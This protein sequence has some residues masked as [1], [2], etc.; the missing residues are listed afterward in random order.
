[1]RDAI[2]KAIQRTKR[3][4]GLD[5]VTAE[6]IIE[7]GYLTNL[8]GFANYGTIITEKFTLN[9]VQD[10]FNP[11]VENYFKF[12]K[13]K[14]ANVYNPN[15]SLVSERGINNVCFST[16]HQAKGLE[17]SHVFIGNDIYYMPED[18]EYDVE[19]E[20]AEFNLAYVCMTRAKES[21]SLESGSSLH[22]Q[23]QEAI[24]SGF[25]RKY[26]SKNVIVEEKLSDTPQFIAK[27]Q[28]N[29]TKEIV[30]KNVMFLDNASYPNYK[31]ISVVSNEVGDVQDLA[32]FNDYDF[33]QD[34][35]MRTYLKP[36]INDDIKQIEDSW[37]LN[38]EQ[39]KLHEQEIMLEAESV[40]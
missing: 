31:D 11:L 8:R 1:V 33:S 25:N 2:K 14:E 27:W 19:S 34:G 15:I 4:T 30:T 21:L 24:E 38:S 40:F 13:I 5:E 3:K 18:V 10:I 36:S 12:C 26:V 20:K 22:P 39:Q 23:L 6:D 17:F 9:D 35:I 32:V 28:D 7:C 29:D 37:N 16:G